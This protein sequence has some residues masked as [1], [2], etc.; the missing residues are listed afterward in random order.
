MLGSVF[1]CVPP[2][3]T[4][5]VF[6][7][8]TRTGD[9]IQY[10][11]SLQVCGSTDRR[12]TPGTQLL[13]IPCVHDY[14]HKILPSASA[15]GNFEYRFLV[16]PNF[17]RNERKTGRRAAYVALINHYVTSI[18]VA[19]VLLLLPTEYYLLPRLTDSGPAGG[20]FTT[21]T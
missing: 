19:M 7:V 2:E 12:A 21:R 6:R 9:Q 13:D 3:R 11:V 20:S 16:P 4:F 15:R 18:E 1:G 14:Y 5:G 17:G 10:A 8:K